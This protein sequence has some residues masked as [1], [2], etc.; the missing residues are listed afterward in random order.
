MKHTKPF[1]IIIAAKKDKTLILYNIFT[2]KPMLEKAENHRFGLF[3][4]LSKM[5]LILNYSL[6]PIKS[7]LLLTSKDHSLED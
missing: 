1:I 2:N 5:L 4:A 3:L 7:E 6:L